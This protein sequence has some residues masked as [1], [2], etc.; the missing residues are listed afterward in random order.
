M[1]TPPASHGRR[2]AN[3]TLQSACFRGHQSQS[4]PGLRAILSQCAVRQ[5]HRK[6][7]LISG[8]TGNAR[9]TGNADDGSPLPGGSGNELGNKTAP[10]PLKTGA[11]AKLVAEGMGLTSNLL[12]RKSLIE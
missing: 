9:K 7:W 5:G 10:D 8:Q 4:G 11:M 3:P 1:F 6:R 2:E 12:H